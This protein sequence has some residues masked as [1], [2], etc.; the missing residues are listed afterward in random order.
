MDTFKF[1][2][3][4]KYIKKTQNLFDWFILEQKGLRSKRPLLARRGNVH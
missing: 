4:K 2:K 3:L 1:N